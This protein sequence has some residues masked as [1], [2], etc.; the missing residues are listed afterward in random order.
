MLPPQ[1]MDEDDMR[2]II[3]GFENS[4]PYLEYDEAIEALARHYDLVLDRDRCFPY[5]R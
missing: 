3:V 1:G 2:P 5:A 4:D